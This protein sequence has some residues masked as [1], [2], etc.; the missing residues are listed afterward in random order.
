M[1]KNLIILCTDQMRSDCLGVNGRNPDIWT[2]KM[3]A[4]ARRGVNFRRHF[5]T[6][7]GVCL[8]RI[9]MMTG[10]YCH[11]DGYR[12]ITQHMPV[13]Y[14]DLLSTMRRAGYKAALFGKNHC[15]DNLFEATHRPPQ[16]KEG[17]SGIA[18]DHHS[19]TEGYAEIYKRWQEI[20]AEE[21]KS[22]DPNPNK[23]AVRWPAQSFGIRWA[24]A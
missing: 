20:A 4:L 23:L 9:S 16:L 1:N 3:D 18:I 5:T 17:Q 22:S 15:W 10:R 8:A 2:P 11:T 21:K 24:K 14:P 6:M 7:P 19:W 13:Q 12:T